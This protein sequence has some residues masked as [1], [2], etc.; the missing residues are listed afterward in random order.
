[1]RGGRSGEREDVRGFGGPSARVVLSSRRRA[2]CPARK[3]GVPELEDWG[4][5]GME[6]GEVALSRASGS[7]GASQLHQA[8]T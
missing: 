4:D 1:M 6:E 2:G 8:L 7:L 3:V 5:G